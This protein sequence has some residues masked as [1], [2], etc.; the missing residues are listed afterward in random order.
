MNPKPTSRRL[1]TIGVPVIA[2]L[3]GGALA[4]GAAGAPAEP[5]VRTET[6]TV[7]ETV[8]TT[9]QSCIDALDH[10]ESLFGKFADALDIAGDSIMAAV[11]FDLD[12]LDE[13]T[14]KLEEM[15]PEVADIR[16]DYDAAAMECRAS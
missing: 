16:S 3:V 1:F 2:F 8:E 4:T 15:T 6:E 14:A 11:N 13:G 5:E 7:T 9:P 10:S 12:A